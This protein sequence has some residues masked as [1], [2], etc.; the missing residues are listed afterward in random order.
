VT[1]PRPARARQA[2]PASPPAAA[3]PKPRAG[4]PDERPARADLWHAYQLAQQHYEL[5]LQLFS[6]RMNLFL[7]IQS[8]LAAFVGGFRITGGRLIVDRAAVA[9]FGLAL[10]VAWLVVAIS[11]YMWVKTWRTRWIALGDLLW[12]KAEIEVSSRLFT[13]ERR[14]QA[15]KS[16]YGDRQWLWRQLEAVSWFARPTLISCCLPLLFMLG[17][18]Y[19]GWLL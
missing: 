2:R 6:S 18:I 4:E 5:D 1:S 15:L 10:A 11:S 17:W 13:H 12:D 3:V 14:R 7:V 8:A 19:L 9:V 16:E